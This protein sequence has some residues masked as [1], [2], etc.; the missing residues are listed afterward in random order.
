MLDKI[1]DL[2]INISKKETNYALKN[3]YKAC[4][5]GKFTTNSNY[6]AAETHYIKYKNYILSDLYGPILKILY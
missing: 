1:P 2:I 4:I 3:L 6:S 5:K